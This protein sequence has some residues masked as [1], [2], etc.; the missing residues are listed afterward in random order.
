MNKSLLMLLALGRLAAE[1]SAE[2]PWSIAEV[3][4]ADLID[5]FGQDAGTAGAGAARA[6][7]GLVADQVWVLD[8]DVPAEGVRPRALNE[9]HVAGRLTPDLERVLRSSPG[10]IGET[11]R[12]LAVRAFPQGEVD[13]VLAAVGLMQASVTGGQWHGGRPAA[14]PRTGQRRGTGSL[15]D[16]LKLTVSRA[17]EQ[18]RV[19]LG[20]RPVADGARQADFMPVETLL[21]L[22]ASFRVSH[23]R[24]GGRTA[25]LAPEPVPELARLFTRRPS[26]VLAKM[27][28]LDGS[29]SHGAAFDASAGATLREQPTLFA[30]IYRVL[31]YAA[32]AEGIGRDRLPDFLAL[33]DGGEVE[34]LGQEEL[35]TL[36]ADDL[37]GLAGAQG[38][39]RPDPETERIMTA[40]ARVGQH[41]FAQNVL[42]N[43]G[44]SCVFCGLRPAAFGARRMLL[45]GHIKPWRDSSHR[46]RLD[47]S[48]G[49]AG[50]PSHDVA[51]DT[52]LLTVDDDLRIRLSASLS[53]AV[54]VDQ[55]A[56]QYYGTPPMLTT[57]GLPPTAQ[58]PG[59]GYLG[60]HRSHVFADRRPTARNLLGVSPH[61]PWDVRL[62]ANRFQARGLNVSTA[63][64]RCLSP[65]ARRSTTR[66]TMAGRWPAHSVTS[67]LPPRP[68]Q[69]QCI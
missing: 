35:A 40:A 51:F 49:L 45:A 50:C 23:R 28:N 1:G 29:R 13:D 68:F 8:T 12:M 44:G 11:A 47:L 21:C 24:Y 36:D 3:M 25:H 55:L 38:D 66:S 58:R 10:L 48:N 63:P 69:S 9:W 64:A 15:D 20:R 37:A 6:F 52:G 27:A 61:G 65:D 62:P 4:L 26:S 54:R 34:L 22:A 33:E 59:A 31:L 41:V 16:Y 67:R 57:L 60:W 43:C 14:G 7:T 46:E 5:R 18:F 19:L 53:D 17:R 56:R 30:H 39:D 32:R 42:T 2:L